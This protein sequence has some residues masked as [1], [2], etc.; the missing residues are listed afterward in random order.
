MVIKVLSNDVIVIDCFK[1]SLYDITVMCKA[2][3]TFAVLK[4]L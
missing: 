4:T 1:K 2:N 3:G